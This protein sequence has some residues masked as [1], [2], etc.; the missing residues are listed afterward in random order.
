MRQARAMAFLFALCSIACKSEPDAV[1][2]EDDAGSS[3][4]EDAAL[5]TV[6]CPEARGPGTMHEGVIDSDETWTATDSP[7]IVTFGVEIDG[8]TLTI[9][10]CAVVRVQ[11]GHTISIGGTA[12]TAGAMLVAHGEIVPRSSGDVRRPVTFLPDTDGTFWGALYVSETGRLDLEVVDISGGGSHATAPNLGGSIV[13][14]GGGGP[15]LVPHVRVVDVRVEDSE[16]FGVN[17]QNFAA[18]DEGSRD[19]VI[20]GSGQTPSPNNYVTDYP[21]L[22]APP[23]LHTIPP[24]TYT[25]NAIDAIRVLKAADVQM[26]ETFPN[27]GV[28]YSMLTDF[29]MK[30][31]DTMADGGIV[32]LGIEAGVRIEFSRDPASTWFLG[33]GVS[34][35]MLPENIWPVRLVAR[36]TA[37][38]PIVLTSGETT[39]AAGDWGGIA[40]AGGPPTGNRVEHVRIEYAGGASGTQGFG[41]GP[42]DNSAALILT[43]WRPDEDFI[44]NLTI[45]D[46]AGGGIVSG[47][48]SD[49]N[50]PDLKAGNTFTNIANGCDVSRWMNE[51]APACPGDDGVADCL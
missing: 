4:T 22:I 26:D 50:G 16:G 7:H 35:G 47:W 1:R 11:E 29:A 36:G 2:S 30:P 10:P 25:G 8:A 9:E 40:W 34:N 28:P 39:P 24:G 31:G 21:L 48:T 38:A 27:R 6:A 3:A 12:G 37:D 5:P 45:S 44:D 43:N 33:L 42:S 41:C 51:S 20:T 15:K 13:A 32:T 18:F 14:S 23:A 19:L 17:L 49:E 46:S